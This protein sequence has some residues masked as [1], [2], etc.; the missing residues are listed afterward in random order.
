MGEPEIWVFLINSSNMYNRGTLFGKKKKKKEP[1]VPSKVW[2]KSSFWV[3]LSKVQC[4]NG[5]PGAHVIIIKWC[6]SRWVIW[7]HSCG[8]CRVQIDHRELASVITPRFQHVCKGQ[9]SSKTA[10][11]FA[12]Q[13]TV[14]RADSWVSLAWLLSKKVMKSSGLCPPWVA[15]LFGLKV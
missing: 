12:Q 8:Q 14:K 6:L 4:K 2:F 3:I 15:L 5:D 13:P 10:V 9:E 7:L 1:T 11:L